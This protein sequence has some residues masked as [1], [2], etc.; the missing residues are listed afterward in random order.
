[1][2]LKVIRNLTLLENNHFLDLIEKNERGVFSVENSNL[3]F[4]GFV[5][6][7]D[8][9]RMEIPMAIQTCKT[10]GIQVRMISGDNKLTCISVGNF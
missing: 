8:I 5:G 3:I 6:L 7:K 9:I 10:A 2:D 1:M 4:C